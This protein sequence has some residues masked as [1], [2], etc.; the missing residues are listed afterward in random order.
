[1]NRR[2][3]VRAAR[4]FVAICIMW[5]ISA[6]GQSSA[7]PPVSGITL[8]DAVRY[9]LEHHPLIG[10]QKAQ[11]TSNRGVKLQATAQ[12]DTVLQSWVQPESSEHSAHQPGGAQ[13]GLSN[14][15]DQ[16]SDLTALNA[17]ASKLFRT[18]VSVSPAFTLNRNANNLVNPVESTSQLGFVVTVPLLRGL[19]RS[20][21]AAPE[22]AAATEVEA[23]LLDLNQLMAQ[24]MANTVT[25]YWNLVATQK[26]LLI[27]ADA[28]H[29]GEVYVDNV[30]ALI[31][32]DH[33]PRT[34]LNDVAANLA[35]RA[36]NRIAAEQQVVVARQQL[37]IDMGTSA[38]DLFTVFDPTDDF[39]PGEDQPLPAGYPRSLQSCLNQAL[40]RRADF[41]AAKRR[42]DKARVLHVAA[43]NALLPQL[44]LN[45]ESWIFAPG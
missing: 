37:A 9:T 33:V 10:E 44:N 22:T 13:T 35:D 8:L 42:I 34:D 3:G 21:V 14:G 39:P 12:F 11:V 19:G 18:G 30:K 24:L 28:E 23:S 16:I 17:S 4:T 36:A 45:F 38:Y 1:M 7:N 32:A 26:L 27:A 2:R 6:M 20:V 40:Q 5:T 29:R 15:A 25:S 41:L 31:D 43:K